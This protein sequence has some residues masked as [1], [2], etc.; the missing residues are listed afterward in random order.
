MADASS[1]NSMLCVCV[2]V[3]DQNTDRKTVSGDEGVGRSRQTRQVHRTRLIQGER[4]PVTS[5]L[6]HALMDR[7]DLTLSPRVVKEAEDLLHD[8]FSV[9]MRAWDFMRTH[10]KELWEK[11]E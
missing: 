5:D 11:R 3:R 7:R 9:G 4:R 1:T 8:C 10:E 6:M 2:L